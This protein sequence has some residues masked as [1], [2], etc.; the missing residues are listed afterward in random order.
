VAPLPAASPA[1]R[2]SGYSAWAKPTGQLDR[3]LGRGEGELRRGIHVARR[4]Y[5]HLRAPAPRP[6]ARPSPAQRAPGRGAGLRCG[7]AGRAGPHGLG[8]CL[9]VAL[10]SPRFGGPAR[11]IPPCTALRGNASARAMVLGQQVARGRAPSLSAPCLQQ[12]DGLLREVEQAHQIAH[13]DAAAPDPSAPPASRVR[14]SSSTSAT[15]ARASS[16]GLRSS[17]RH[18]LDQ[19]QLQRFCVH[20]LADECRDRLEA[21]DFRAARPSG[22][23]QR[24]ARRSHRLGTHEHGWQQLPARRASRPAPAVLLVKAAA[25]L[26]G[27]GAISSIGSFARLLLAASLPAAET[28]RIASRPLPMPGLA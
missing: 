13:R 27:M 28:D 12:L 4:L 2:R 25:R 14:P 17:A 19:C 7:A 18:V 20:A 11:T 26:L 1:V 10:A 24:S 16:I 8:P 22:A 5:T 23:R 3:L 6:S 15:H 9:R 21:R